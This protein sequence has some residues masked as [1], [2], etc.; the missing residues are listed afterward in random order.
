M[1]IKAKEVLTIRKKINSDFPFGLRNF[2]HSRF[3]LFNPLSHVDGAAVVNIDNS[4]TGNSRRQAGTVLRMQLLLYDF[5]YARQLAL[6]IGSKNGCLMV[7]NGICLFFFFSF[8]FLLLF[9][10]LCVLEEEVLK[11][12]RV[13]RCSR[14]CNRKGFGHAAEAM[15]A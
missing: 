10:L 1:I 5:I 2:N 7:T 6:R 12:Q 8:F 15:A 13:M 14:S 4:H 3:P 9:L 11:Y